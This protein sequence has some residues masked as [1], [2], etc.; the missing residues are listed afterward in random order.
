MKKAKFQKSLS[1]SLP[2]AMY[3][4]IKKLS[5]AR[6]VSMGEIAREL[7]GREIFDP[8]DTKNERNIKIRT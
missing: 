8:E 4:K 6:E 3:E 2:I 5:D 7:L 1:V